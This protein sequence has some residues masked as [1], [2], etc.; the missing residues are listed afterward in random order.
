MIRDVLVLSQHHVDIFN[1]AP[2]PD[3]ISHGAIYVARN[4]P[5]RL[6]SRLFQ[7]KTIVIDGEVQNYLAGGVMKL[8]H[9]S[10]AGTQLWS[11]PRGLFTRS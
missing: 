9:S 10:G 3:P 6:S 5:C 2:C 7:V 8:R 11:K 1:V 4:R